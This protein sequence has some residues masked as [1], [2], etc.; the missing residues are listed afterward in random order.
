MND[1]FSGLKRN[2]LNAIN[3]LK[4]TRFINSD[5]DVLW[6][7]RMTKTPGK[8][9]GKN[10]VKLSSSLVTNK[11]DLTSTV[12]QLIKTVCIDKTT[13]SWW[14]K[15]KKIASGG[16]GLIY[17]SLSDANVVI[18]IS[19]SSYEARVYAQLGSSIYLAKWFG[20]GAC[21][22]PKYHSFIVLEKFPLDLNQLIRTTG[23]IPHA[24]LKSTARDVI[25]ALQFV[26]DRGYVHCDLKPH[27]VLLSGSQLPCRA[28]LVDFGLAKP[29]DAEPRRI[30]HRF[31]TLSYMSCDVHARVNPTRRSDM[32]SFGWVLV[33]MFDGKLPWTHS[34]VDSVGASKCRYKKADIAD[35]LS[36]VSIPDCVRDYLKR[37][38]NLSYDER[39]DYT[40][41]INSFD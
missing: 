26:H 2:N 15:G 18:K 22:D 7:N 29:L 17:A 32:E 40:S 36:I 1:I 10:R 6:S 38:W 12:N 37:T 20:S 24:L 4:L 21:A 16:F 27:N 5:M 39:P 23:A 19:T 35:F 30:N 33:T 3:R 9:I 14:I 28:V 13:N 41:L 8:F 11:E 25:N 34:T 31:G